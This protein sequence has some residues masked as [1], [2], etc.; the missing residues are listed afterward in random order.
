MKTINGL[1][2]TAAV[3]L[4]GLSSHL[5][6]AEDYDYDGNQVDGDD[7]DDNNANYHQFSVCADSYFVVEELS[8]LCDSPGQYYYGGNKYRNSA[9]CTGGDKVRYQ[10]EFAVPYDLPENT[11]P[12]LTLDVEGYGT[13][14]SV[15]VYDSQ[16]LCEI[17]DLWSLNGEACG[18]P[19]QFAMEGYFYFGDQDDDYDYKFKPHIV[20]GISSYQ[21]PNVYDLGGANT[22]KCAG[23]TFNSWTNVAKTV[24]GPLHAF[25]VTMGVFCFFA[26]SIAAAYMYF[27]RN[28]VYRGSAKEDPFVTDD[29]AAA[30][31]IATGDFIN[32]EDVKRMAMMSREQDLIDA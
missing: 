7:G 31:A 30:A 22:K 27:K 6:F 25:I 14:E 8:V 21:N 24:S 26:C 17:D 2:T 11:V 13:V 5:V 23:A 28:Y 18:E 3:L 29:E 4:C 9:Q 16:P 10:I 15:R 20:V 19:G 1:T 32:E 12:Y